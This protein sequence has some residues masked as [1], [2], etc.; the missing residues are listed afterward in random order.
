M[1]TGSSSAA[2]PVATHLPSRNMVTTSATAFT[3]SKRWEM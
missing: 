1:S 3:S 2:A